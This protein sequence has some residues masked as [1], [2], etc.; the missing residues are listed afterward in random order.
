MS[1]EKI[2]DACLTEKYQKIYEIA[3]ILRNH[4]EICHWLDFLAHTARYD[5]TSCLLNFCALESEHTSRLVCDHHRSGFCLCSTAQPISEC[6][7]YG[8]IKFL[9]W[10][11]N[12]DKRR[13]GSA[14]LRPQLW[15]II[16][17]FK[18]I[19]NEAS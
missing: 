13:G 14:L 2:N 4:C 18:V 5:K 7:V 17:E 15:C 16:F 12:A 11:F 3:D 1:V 10:K 9:K 8:P 19:L 6:W